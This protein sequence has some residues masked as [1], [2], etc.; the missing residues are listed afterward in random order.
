[1]NVRKNKPDEKKKKQKKNRKKVKRTPPSSS[2]AS[3]TNPDRS[4]DEDESDNDDD[5]V[6]KKISCFSTESCS[7]KEKK[8]VL[9]EV[10]PFQ[11]PG[12]PAKK[13]KISSDHKEKRKKTE[14]ITKDNFTGKMWSKFSKK[15]E[16]PS[17]KK[18]KK[19]KLSLIHI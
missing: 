17:E 1:M 10:V 19:K 8:C 6:I 2:S 16:E 3:D 14:K 11:T 9:G 13:T 7:G 4:E 15:Q 12:K 18:K 5:A